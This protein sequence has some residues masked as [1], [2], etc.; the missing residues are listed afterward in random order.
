LKFT[1]QLLRLF[2][3]LLFRPPEES[4]VVLDGQFC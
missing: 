2:T 1:L 4:L 3:Q